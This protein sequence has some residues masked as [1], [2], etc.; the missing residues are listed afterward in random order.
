MN[1]IR[2]FIAIELP[3][4][5]RQQL[6]EM[7]QELQER[8]LRTGGEAARKA[9]RWV[10]AENIHLTLKFLGEVSVGNL[11]QLARMLRAETSRYTPFTMTIGGMGAF[12]NLR[13]PR[14]IWV[15][16]EAPPALGALQRAI[17]T[18]ARTLGYPTEE[19]DFSPHLTLGRVS[20]NATPAEIAA[21]AQALAG[22]Q[23]KPLTAVRVDQVHLFRSD[24]RPTGAVY[25]SLDHFALG[26]SDHHSTAHNP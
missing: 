23:V 10:P 26:K 15:G 17:E 22:M 1:A 14:V 13:R 16:S 19:R 6:G 5:L 18:G 24:L 4:Q 12:P 9:V 20:Q 21:I 8:C 3:S 2:A 25:T 11:E 7:I